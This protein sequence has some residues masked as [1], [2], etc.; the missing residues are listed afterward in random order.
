MSLLLSETLKCMINISG[1]GLRLKY[2]PQVKH[3]YVHL[4]I[5]HLDVFVQCV[6]QWGPQ[7]WLGTLHAIPLQILLYVLLIP[8]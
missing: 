2:V 8:L 1:M 3:G 6:L 5:E 7:S 4:C